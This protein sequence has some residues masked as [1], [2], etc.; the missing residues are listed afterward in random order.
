MFVKNILHLF[1]SDT[2][3]GGTR[4]G[5]FFYVL[6]LCY[7]DKVVRGTRSGSFFYDLQVFYNDK[8]VCMAMLT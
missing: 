8:L 3:V 7:S 2:A 6:Q 4:S 5:S 1:Y